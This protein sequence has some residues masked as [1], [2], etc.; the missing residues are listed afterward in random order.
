MRGFHHSSD[1]DSGARRM[2]LPSHRRR[3]HIRPVLSVRAID[4]F[5]E[6][7]LR[8]RVPSPA[9][10]AI[11]VEIAAFNSCRLKGFVRKPANPAASQS[12]RVWFVAWAVTAMIGM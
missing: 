9:Q 5:V 6:L 3:P 2:G 4:A 1:R 12:R 7:P 11:T 10:V 8:R